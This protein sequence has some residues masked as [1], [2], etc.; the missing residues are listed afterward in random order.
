[1]EYLNITVILSLLRKISQKRVYKIS[2]KT[3]ISREGIQVFIFLKRD[4]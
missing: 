1:M 4:I 2:F 3:A